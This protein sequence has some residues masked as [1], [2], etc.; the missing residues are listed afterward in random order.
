MLSW[1]A[2]RWLDKFGREWGYDV[3]YM[4]DVLD[5]GGYEALKPMIALQKVSAYRGGAPPDAL[6][7]AGLVAARA[8][9]CGPCLQLGVTMAERGGMRA[10]QIAAVLTH[11]REAMTDDVRIAYDFANAA[12]A[13]DGWDKPA[14]EAAV[15]R[16][17]KRAMIA[18]SY[19]IAVAGFYPAFKYALGA[20]HACQR[21]RVGTRDV[22]PAAV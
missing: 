16:F 1:F 6:F 2:K 20:A 21:I 9:D 4:H 10:E 15:E 17:G 14:R 3:S 11:D 7:T 8:G 18:M 5:A 12:I 13:R 22:V 19:A